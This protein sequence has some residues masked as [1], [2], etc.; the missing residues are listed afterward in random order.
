MG[1]GADKLDA[2][3]DAD[4]SIGMPRVSKPEIE[5]TLVGVV[6]LKAVTLLKAESLFMSLGIAQSCWGF[7]E[8][9]EAI[10]RAEWNRSF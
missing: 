8:W 5:P 10:S 4:P 7:W 1:A 9:D 2:D 3:K 6:L